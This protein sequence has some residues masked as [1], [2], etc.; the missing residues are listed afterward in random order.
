MTAEILPGPWRQKCKARSKS[1]GEPCANWAMRGAFVCHAHG[2][3]APQTRAAAERRLS[4]LHEDA[5]RQLFDQFPYA[6]NVLAEVGSDPQASDRDRLAAARAVVSSVVSWKGSDRVE[7][8]DQE[9]RDLSQEIS[10]L[11][12]EMPATE[13]KRRLARLGDGFDPEQVEAI[14]ADVFDPHEIANRLHDIAR[15]LVDRELNTPTDIRDLRA[16]VDEILK[17]E[18][19]VLGNG[20]MVKMPE[21]ATSPANTNGHQPDPVEEFP[22]I[23]RLVDVLTPVGLTIEDVADLLRDALA[24][25][26]GHDGEDDDGE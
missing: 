6:V 20:E 14:V 22:S 9:A 11:V 5:M 3:K 25:E 23:R 13:V 19:I 18:A 15:R 16:E 12:R 24:G 1:T 10:E 4:D 2:G 7:I 21:D 26:D 8:A 17:A